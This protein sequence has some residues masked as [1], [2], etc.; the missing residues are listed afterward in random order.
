MI[1]RRHR[2]F[3]DEEIDLIT[4]TYLNWKKSIDYK[5]IAGFC[6][7]VDTDLIQEHEFILT[8][9]RYVGSPESKEENYSKEDVKKLFL[10]LSTYLDKSKVLGEDI[11]KIFKEEGYL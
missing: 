5:D 6:K 9:G 1:D 8:P 7:S 11:K 2:E 3:T 4:K 10:E